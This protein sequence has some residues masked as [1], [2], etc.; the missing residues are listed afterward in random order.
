MSRPAITSSEPAVTS[1]LNIPIPV[2]AS[3]PLGEDGV[4]EGAGAGVE[5][6]EV[7]EPDPL[8]F[9]VAGGVTATVTTAVD[10]A[11]VIPVP[12]AVVPP[13]VAVLR[14]DPWAMSAS[15]TL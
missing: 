10:G 15:V 9:P 14:I 1:C 11:E 7:P 13:A 6:R 2:Y 12:A 4:A 8:P 3:G 5:E